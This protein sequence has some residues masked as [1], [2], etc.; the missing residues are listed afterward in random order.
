VVGP[1]GGAGTGAG[2]AESGV[3]AAVDKS[4]SSGI[5]LCLSSPVWSL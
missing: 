4:D 2:G 3:A 1:I 5:L